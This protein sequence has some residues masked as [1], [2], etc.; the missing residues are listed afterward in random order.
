MHENNRI[1]SRQ[2]YLAEN[3]YTSILSTWFLKIS[4]YQ[5]ER[6][7][8]KRCENLTSLLKV[9]SKQCQNTMLESSWISLIRCYEHS[10]VWFRNSRVISTPNSVSYLL[11][12]CSYL[13]PYSS[14]TNKTMLF[15]HQPQFRRMINIICV[16][17]Q[18]KCAEKR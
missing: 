4:K 17:K 1:S 15:V 16:K 10:L 2:N 7:I 3:F 9:F 6:S 11:Q 14:G 8:V 12:L 18:F 5:N 13:S